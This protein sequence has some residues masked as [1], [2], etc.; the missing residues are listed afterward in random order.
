MRR[1]IPA[2]AVEY[3]VISTGLCWHRRRRARHPLQ[4]R[5]R[6]TGMTTGISQPVSCVDTRSLLSARELQRRG[7]HNAHSSEGL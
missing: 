5:P 7:Y 2:I 6:F 4:N 1:E 3:P